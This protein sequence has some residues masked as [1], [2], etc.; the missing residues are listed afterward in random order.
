M[1]IPVAQMA[2]FIFRYNFLFDY[3]TKQ[4]SGKETKA[5]QFFY[6]MDAKAGDERGQKRK[7]GGGDVGER[8]RL[9]PKPTGNMNNVC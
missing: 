3:L 1:V 7:G 4:R 2:V 8:K 6:D 5:G 9:P